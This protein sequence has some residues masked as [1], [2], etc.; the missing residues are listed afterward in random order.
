MGL[1]GVELIEE[2]VYTVM[3]TGRVHGSDPVSAALI[4]EH[5]SGKTSVVMHRPCESII[6][7]NKAT[8]KGLEFSMQMNPK[9]THFLLT[10]MTFVTGMGQKSVKNFIETLKPMIEEGITRIADPSGVKQFAKG[11]FGL[12][13]CLTP[14]L[15]RDQRNWW[16]H[17]GFASRIVPFY[18]IYSDAIVLK[19]KAAIDRDQPTAWKPG[20]ELKIPEVP[21]HVE[22]TDEVTIEARKFSDALA[23]GMKERGIRLLKQIRTMTKAHAILRTSKWKN[24]RTTMEDVDFLKRIEKF[25]SWDSPAIIGGKFNGWKES[26]VEKQEEAT[27]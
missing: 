18:Y 7:M 26:E 16:W 17:H 22:I 20:E 8:A 3:L 14:Q 5:E 9:A 15:A 24:P 13:G 2:F 11:K 12:I 4:S 21:V 6:V 25:I 19:I 1:I 10:D 27:A 23:V